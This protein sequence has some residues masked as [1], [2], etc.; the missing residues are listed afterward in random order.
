MKIIKY[1]LGICFSAVISTAAVA[2]W[3]PS[4]PIN[5][6]IGFGAGGSTDM[7]GRAIGKEIEDQ[8]GWKVVVENKPGGG[9]IAMFTKIA[10]AKPDGL[11]IGMGVS[12]PTLINLVM[13]GDKLTFD[14]DSF[15]YLAT[16]A[17]A[18]LAMVARSDAPFDNIAGLIEHS[19]SKGGALVAFDAKPQELVMK[20]IDGKSGAGFKLVSTESGAEMIQNLLGGHVDAAFNGGP[21]IQYLES[22]D[23]K[24]LASVSA[25]RFNYSPDTKTLIEQGYQ[26]YVDPWWYIAA[27]AGLPSDAK[28]TLAKAFNSAINSENVSKVVQNVLK[29]QPNNLGPE[30][31]KEMMV[32]GLANIAVLFGK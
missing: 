26:I 28:E 16:V 31:S 8:Y 30:G 7:L 5:L 11:K 23:L 25:S 6:Q 14:L 22:G 15:D 17:N 4:G 18:Q 27:P 19:K 24:M 3:K 12:M 13:R 32:G 10:V 21:H 29:L 1:L 9:G 2:D 20:I